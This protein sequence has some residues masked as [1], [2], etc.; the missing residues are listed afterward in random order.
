[1]AAALGLLLYS[2]AGNWSHRLG[3]RRVIRAGFGIRLFA[4]LLILVL[5]IFQVSSL[6][7][8]ALLGF[9]LIVLAWSLLSVSSTALAAE[10]SP[11]GEGAGLGLF[12]ATTALA[13]VIGSI[14]GGW[15]ASQAGFL[16]AVIFSTA[17]ILFGLILFVTAQAGRENS[18][19]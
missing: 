9:C 4:I 7:W 11:N 12:N 1:V 10:L 18:R 17:G 14:L 16:A 15:I 5:G 3:T 6:G 8:A 19:K 2:P 13:G